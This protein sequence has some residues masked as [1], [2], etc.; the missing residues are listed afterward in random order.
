M[1]GF[2]WRVRKVSGWQRDVW[3]FLY[4]VNLEPRH[5][6][7]LEQDREILSGVRPGLEKFEMLY[8][9]DAGVIRMRRYLA[10]QV[11]NQLVNLEAAGKLH[12][13]N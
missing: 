11:R 9:H 8:Q 3:R 10:Q 2:F 1:A 4:R 5:W 6:A 7:V 13:V 12:L